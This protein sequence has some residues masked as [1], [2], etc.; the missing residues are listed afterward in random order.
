MPIV[1]LPADTALRLRSRILALS[2]VVTVKMFPATTVIPA[3]GFTPAELAEC[4]AQSG[5]AIILGLSDLAP[6]H[7]AIPEVEDGL[8]NYFP[9]TNEKVIARLDPFAPGQK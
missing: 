8:R 1:V 6:L 7:D 4:D 9:V 3:M 5:E 2:Q